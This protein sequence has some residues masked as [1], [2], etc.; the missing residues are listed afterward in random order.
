MNEKTLKPTLT[1]KDF[2]SDQDVR[3]CPGCGDYSI[4]TQTQKIMPEFDIPKEKIVFVAGIGCS[5]RF[6]YYMNTYGFHTIHGR[7]PTIASGIKI[8]NPDLNVWVITGD[9]DALSIGGNHLIHV[10]RRNLD[11]NIIMFNNEI[12]GL[13]K[14][15]YSPTSKFG[16]KTKSSPFGSIDMPFNTPSVVLGA[17]ATFFAR[18]IDSQPKHLQYTLRRSQEHIGS[19]FIEVFQNCIIFNDKAFSHV[20]DRDV[21]DDNVIDLKNGE[22]MI[23]GKNQD[24]GIKLDGF[25]PEVVSIKDN[26]S[27]DDLLIHD[28]KDRNLASILANFTEN[29]SLPTP[30]GVFY[31]EEKPRYE[32]LLEE[33]LKE[34]IKNMGNGGLN[35]LIAGSDSWKVS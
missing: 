28:E 12:Y 23:F 24:K 14:G 35:K 34:S 8:S 21:R 5:S 19:S 25:S 16:Q 15:Q 30:I 3:W 29:E 20:T 32:E 18:T 10:L 27:T 26:V 6:P 11:L 1:R 7:A 17:K 33:Q 31:S 4:L 2:V 9:G 13:T 22:P